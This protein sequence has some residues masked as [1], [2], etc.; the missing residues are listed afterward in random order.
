MSL[1]SIIVTYQ[2]EIEVISNLVLGNIN[3]FNNVIVVDNA[4]D[5]IKQISELFSDDDRVKLISL[6]KNV[7]IATAQ[8][9]GINHL[10][11]DEDELIVFFDQD[12]SV[13]ENFLNTLELEYRELDNES[14]SRGVIL[15]PSFFHREKNFEY[16]VVK[17]NKYGV[18]KKILVSQFREAVEV[19]CIISSGM[20]VKKSILDRVGYMKDEL[21]IDYVDTE[22]CLRAVDLGYQVFVSPKLV[23]QHEIG[24][25]NIKLLKW[26]VPVHSAKRRYYR[27]RNSFY[28]GRYKYIPKLVVIKE[29]VFSVLHQFVLV[30]FADNKIQHLKSL[31]LGVK[32]GLF[33]DKHQC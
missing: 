4:S 12:S 3:I 10:G 28:L 16:P 27:V 21:F 2:P 11:V 33:V 15:G 20:C 17:I 7:G 23:M 9:I 13:D 25:D 26:R 18:I 14:C 1:S 6:D 22:W 8:N 24:I 30:L 19:S 32:D 29:I 5:N 31:C